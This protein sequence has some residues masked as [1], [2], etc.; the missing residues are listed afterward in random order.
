MHNHLLTTSNHNRFLS[1]ILL[2]HTIQI[3]IS[4]LSMRVIVPS[5]M[6]IQAKL[7]FIII[8]NTLRNVQKSLDEN[9]RGVQRYR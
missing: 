1:H 7:D 4:A 3:T 6:S 9:R 5:V 8:I 2:V